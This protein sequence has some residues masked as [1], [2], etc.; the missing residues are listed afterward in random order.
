MNVFGL[1]PARGGSKSIPRKNIAALSGRPLIAYTCDA[2]HD[3]R[4]L[5]R[6]VISTDDDQIAQVARSH[7]VETPFVRPASLAT[8]RTSMIDVVQ[9]AIAWL[10]DTER[11]FPDIVVVLQPTSPLRTHRH[12]DEAIELLIE[13]SADSVVSVVEVP[14]QYTP[15]SVMRVVDGRLV[16][17]ISAPPVFRRQDKELFYA[18]NGPAVVVTRPQI[19]ASGRLYGDN[20]RP[21]LMTHGDSIDV[22]TSEDLI[23]AEFWLSRRIKGE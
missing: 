2:A 11:Y 8:D 6:T 12:I 1:I 16:D 7:G 20:L 3:S 14:H 22:D 23:A 17:F 18:R 13:T 15:N 9:H 4:R 19:V 10:A 21:Y 5:T